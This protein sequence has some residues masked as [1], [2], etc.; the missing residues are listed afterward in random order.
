MVNDQGLTWVFWLKK[1]GLGKLGFTFEYYLS[2]HL[3]IWEL[4]RLVR[5]NVLPTKAFIKTF[6]QNAFILV[7]IKILLE[8]WGMIGKKQVYPSPWLLPR[9][10]QIGLILRK[11]KHQGQYSQLGRITALQGR[12]GVMPKCK[13]FT[14]HC[15]WGACC[16][17]CLTKIGMWASVWVNGWLSVFCKMMRWKKDEYLCCLWFF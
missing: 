9:L 1:E 6:I 7:Y 17:L 8:H 10:T 2:W 3:S 13:L 11:A 5:K 15:S 16:S 12:E 14:E 4:C